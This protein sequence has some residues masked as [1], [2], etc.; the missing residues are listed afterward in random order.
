MFAAAR[1]ALDSLRIALSYPA[2][3][4]SARSDY[5]AKAEL[6]FSTKEFS[7]TRDGEMIAI[8][9]EVSE[10]FDMHINKLQRR[11][12]EIDVA[13]NEAQAKLKYLQRDYKSELNGAYAI[14][15]SKRESRQ[16]CSKALREAHEELASAKSSLSSWYSKAEGNWF[17][18][19]GRQLPQKSFFGQDISE[20]DRYKSDRDAAARS[21]SQLHAGRDQLD[22]DLKRI[23]ESIASIKS[24]RQVMFDLKMEGFEPHFLVGVIESSI[25]QLVEIDSKIE[26]ETSNRTIFQEQE[27][28]RRGVPELDSRIAMTLSDKR[29][30]LSVFDTPES[31]GERKALH[32][33]EWLKLHSR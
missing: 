9:K 21:V 30:H 19:G 14:L 11:R 4:A 13:R 29:T 28:I 3:E 20:R 33:R 1:K 8:A 22:K 24:D 32:R 18:N 16:S 26:Q 31:R 12:H 5:Y 27:M 23:R 6:R 2:Y 7:A 17:G 25:S 10:R 15:N